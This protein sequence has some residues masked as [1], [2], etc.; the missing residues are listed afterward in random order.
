MSH[1]TF[2]WLPKLKRSRSLPDL[3]LETGIYPRRVQ[4]TKQEDDSLGGRS[5]REHW[6]E[7]ERDNK[8]RTQIMP[9]NKTC[10]DILKDGTCASPVLV[11]RVSDFTTCV[12]VEILYISK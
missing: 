10:M 8:R 11:A 12:N 3:F 1:R 5:L 2:I 4:F 7:K 9:K 6:R